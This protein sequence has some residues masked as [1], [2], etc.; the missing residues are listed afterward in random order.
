MPGE[1]CRGLAQHWP[2]RP[3]C[4]VGGD[5]TYSPTSCYRRLTPAGERGI[6]AA[7]ASLGGRN[8]GALQGKQ[9]HWPRQTK[10][11]LKRTQRQRPTY[12]GAVKNLGATRC[13]DRNL[14]ATSSKVET[15]TSTTMTT[16]QHKMGIKSSTSSIMKPCRNKLN[17][18]AFQQNDKNFYIENAQPSRV[19][20]K[21]Q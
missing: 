21:R 12:K 3:Y 17:H 1:E 13:N 5:Q 14:G 7:P 4:I 19:W 8:P 18:P 15:K 20:S 10:Q 16:K 11:R 9:Q 2:H 6:N